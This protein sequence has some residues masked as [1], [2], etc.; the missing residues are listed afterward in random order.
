MT[1]IFPIM[2]GFSKFVS[3]V[4]GAR[5]SPRLMLAGGLMATAAVNIAFGFGASMWWFSFFWALNGILQVTPLA[6]STH[7][8]CFPMTIGADGG[9]P[10]QLWGL[11]LSDMLQLLPQ[12]MH[13]LRLTPIVLHSY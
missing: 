12:A 1:S 7:P 13:P 4:L 6:S 11:C 5:T 10:G 8:V 9:E 3:G 2:Y